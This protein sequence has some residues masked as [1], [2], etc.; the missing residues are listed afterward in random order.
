MFGT[1]KHTKARR[2]VRRGRFSGRA[3]EGEARARLVDER[4]ADDE[5]LARAADSVRALPSGAL[6][7]R[8]GERV[9][10]FG[11][12]LQDRQ[13]ARR[14][15]V[16]LVIRSLAAHGAQADP[17]EVRAP[18]G[19][20]LG[21]QL[22]IQLGQRRL[23]A[24]NHGARNRVRASGAVRRRAARERATHVAQRLDVEQLEVTR[25]AA[26]HFAAISVV[27]EEVEQPAEVRCRADAG[28]GQNDAERAVRDD[29]CD[30]SD[31]AVR[32]AAQR[33]HRRQ[34]L[35]ERGRVARGADDARGRRASAGRVVVRHFIRDGDERGDGQ[36]RAENLRH[37][38]I[39]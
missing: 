9:P 35:A 19:H 3:R 22:Q 16:T 15:I 23:D 1:W 29:L 30:A 39:A 7:E 2:G 32:R 5:A 4:R 8:E 17:D 12:A 13:V 34:Q 38:R 31:R 27:L 36:Q 20:L 28:R 14:D 26:A 25:L 24:L 21:F 37:L 11:L 18:R 33:Q 10:R 6:G